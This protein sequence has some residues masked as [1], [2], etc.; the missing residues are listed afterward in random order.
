M[1]CTIAKNRSTG[2]IA[3]LSRH[4]PEEGAV[5]LDDNLILTIGA[6]KSDIGLRLAGD[7]DPCE[8]ARPE[9]DNP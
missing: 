5:S 3:R 4:Y 7:R 9:C 6:L 8:S 2:R 1:P